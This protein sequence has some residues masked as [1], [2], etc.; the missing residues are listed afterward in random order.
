MFSNYGKSTH[1][2]LD[3]IATRRVRLSEEGPGRQKRGRRRGAQVQLQWWRQE[4][5]ISE[6]PDTATAV[7]RR[8]GA[9]V[10][11][12]WWRQALFLSESPGTAAAVG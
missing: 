12:Q 3:T 11:L 10:Q 9:Q 7:V 2:L 8:R 4:M 6:S 1:K 5:F